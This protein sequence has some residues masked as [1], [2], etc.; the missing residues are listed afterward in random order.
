[1]AETDAD[2]AAAAD[3]V[4][5]VVAEAA[6]AAEHEAR[7]VADAAEAAEAEA[8]ADEADLAEIAEM[9]DME[10]MEEEPE[11]A[12]YR[13]FGARSAGGRVP[14]LASP[15]S[16]I[17][18]QIT[19]AIVILNRLPNAIEN[20]VKKELDSVARKAEKSREWVKEHETGLMKRADVSSLNLFL[21]WGDLR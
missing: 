6:D 15:F 8:V 20:Q 4:A 21:A 7:K 12:N 13:E 5:R 1:M 9:E 14:D 2:A 10:N 11:P 17:D 18:E 3:E 19:N 16:A